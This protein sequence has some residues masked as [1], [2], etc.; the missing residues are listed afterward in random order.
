[1]PGLLRERGNEKVHR[2]DHGRQLPAACRVDAR[3]AIACEDRPQVEDAAALEMDHD[4]CVGGPRTLADDLGILARQ[5]ELDDLRKS[6]GRQ[7]IAAPDGTAVS[8]RVDEP[9]DL[10]DRILIDQSG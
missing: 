6:H 1:M 3:I 7:R 5:M 2:L 10:L 4:V 8:A 9:Q